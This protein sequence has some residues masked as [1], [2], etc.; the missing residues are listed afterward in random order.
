MKARNTF[1]KVILDGEEYIEFITRGKNNV[2]VLVDVEP[3]ENYLY[4]RSNKSSFT[5][6]PPFLMNI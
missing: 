3:W 4:R 5:S 6:S 1:R 2:A